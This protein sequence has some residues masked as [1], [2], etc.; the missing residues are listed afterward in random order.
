MPTKAEQIISVA[1]SQIG[2]HETSPN[3]GPCEK[4]QTI[5]GEQYR[6][7]EWCG[8]FVGWVWSQV[9]PSWK[10]LA[11]PGTSIMC[12]IARDRDLECEPR[13]GAAFVIC[14]THTGLLH[15]HLGGDSWRTIEGNSS[16]QVRWGTR[17]VGGMT[18]YAPPELGAEAEAATPAQATWF[19]LQDARLVETKHQHAY[20][21]GFASKDVR[22]QRLAELERSLGHELR[23]FRDNNFP[24]PFF[25]D[26][27]FAIA[28][29][30]GGW[31]D[32]AGRDASK[33]VL[34]ERLGRSL[35]PF[36]ETRNA[37]IGGAPWGLRGLA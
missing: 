2:I 17:S 18:V 32:K 9:D 31:S 3:R 4:F 10:R 26:N 28:E 5:Y 16:D 19:F 27:S 1:E 12:D 33:A 13:P 36:S 34:E 6:G 23:P 20:F 30:Y 35:R 24:S 15:S 37:A 7:C 11:S 14:G 21:G 8:C 25:I 29:V 22:D